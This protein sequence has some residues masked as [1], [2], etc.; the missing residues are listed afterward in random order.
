MVYQTVKVS[1][2]KILTSHVP[3]QTGAK[4]IKSAAH[5]GWCCF[6]RVTAL[7]LPSSPLTPNENP[8]SSEPNPTQSS[9]SSPFLII[10]FIIT[11]PF[12]IQSSSEKP[13]VRPHSSSKMASQCDPRGV[14]LGQSLSCFRVGELWRVGRLRTHRRLRPPR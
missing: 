9:A 4:R 11:C 1:P 10:V 7:A 12:S 3:L 6:W 14:A 8:N 5:G 13:Q 2:L